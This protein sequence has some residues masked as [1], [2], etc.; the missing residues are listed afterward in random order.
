MVRDAANREIQ[1][2]VIANRHQPKRGKQLLLHAARVA[3]FAII[4]LL[5]HFQHREL[6]ETRQRAAMATGDS[7]EQLKEFFPAATAVSK[8]AK[9]DGSRDVFDAAGE[10]LG[11]VLQTSPQCDYLVGF[12]G[13][14]NT[15]IAVDADDKI[16]GIKI[17]HS[18]DTRNHVRQV[19]QSESFIHA[20]DGLPREKVIALENLDGVSGA[21]LTSLAIREGILQRLRQVG[22]V[23]KENE[24][25]SDSPRKSLRFPEPLTAENVQPLFKDADGVVQDADCRSL[26]HVVDATGKEIG[27]VLRTSPYADNVVGYQGPTETYIGLNPDG[28]IIGI[29]VGKSYDNQPY[30]SYVAEDEYGFLPLFNEKTLP[31]LAELDLEAAGI[32]GVSGA[33]MTSMAV[34]RGL[35]VAATEYEK[36]IATPA[37][38]SPESKSDIQDPAALRALSWTWRDF[39]TAAVVLA[40]V[41]VAF[42]SLRGKKWVRIGLQAGLIGY[43]GLI[44]GDLLSQAM[45][46]GWSQNG[47]PWSNAGGLVLLTAAALLIPISTGRNVYCTHLCP[48]GAAQQLLKNRLP[49]KVSLPNWLMNVL[50]YLPAVLLVWCV[51]V[52]MVGLGFSLV[53]IEPFDAYIFRI[54]GW[55]TISVA[56]VGLVASLFVPMAY[57]RFGC[58]TGA[59]LSFLRFHGKSDVWSRRD[60]F[61]VGLVALALGIYMAI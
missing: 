44:N 53:D 31:E 4:L 43:L 12:S 2:P 56:V 10:R 57:C 9:S 17:L 13:P 15:L 1:L 48:H 27:S 29:W 8:E 61:A 55:A 50:K 22:R 36:E 20:F 23:A 3:L 28:K 45:L 47:V 32:E 5:I 51:L 39:G 16:I 41:I 37:E 19:R 33:T 54:A 46:V 18:Q 59:L 25:V 30:V 34:A 49:G 52:P 11:Y 42:T 35:T 40:G 14:T 58:P 26:W 6:S 60:W 38:E 24:G 21:T 7:V